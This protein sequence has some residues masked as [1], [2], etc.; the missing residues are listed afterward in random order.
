MDFVPIQQQAEITNLFHATTKAINNGIVESTL[1]ERMRFFRAW[2]QWLAIKFPKV[3]SDLQN[4]NR[5]AQ[6]DLLASFACYVRQGSVSRKTQQV[7][8]QT[9]AVA[10]R[11]ISTQ[12]QLDGKQNP[13]VNSEGKYPKAISQILEGF[14]RD[15]SPTQPMLAVP[16]SVPV[17]LLSAA[18]RKSKKDKAVAD[19]AII[20]FYFLL[21]VGEYTYHKKS[22]RRRTKQFRTN[23]I[24]LWHNNTRLN[25]FL[26][27]EELIR[28]CTSA[29]LSISNQKNGKRSQ[30]IHHETTNTDSCPI[31][32]LIRR[33]KHIQQ[34]TNDN[35]II[36]SYFS[37][38]HVTVRTTLASDM[39]KAVKTA[40]EDLG[41]QRF[42]LHAIHVGSHSLRAGGAIAMH[43]AGGAH[44]I[45]KK[46]GRW[47]SDTF[48]MYIHEQI[49]ALSSGVSKQMSQ[50]FEFHN[51]AFQPTHGPMLHSA[52]A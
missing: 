31:R 36:G 50:S 30:V 18:K 35:A 22:D 13:L 38:K 2:T 28:L 20:A 52:A 42:G 24:A 9:V 39:N 25:P 46:M 34:Y 47:S 8:A 1:R 6:L 23:D 32:A 15:D 14:R 10:L 33:L 21:R 41:L 11:S 5:K 44:S 51:I 48:L 17:Y 19:L 40:V 3:Q 45:I 49:A 4:V 7:R 26:P 27:E 37:S 29:T 16:L 12:L 43:L